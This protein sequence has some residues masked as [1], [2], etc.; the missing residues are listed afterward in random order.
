MPTSSLYGN[1]SDVV[2]ANSSAETT[3]LYTHTVSFGV[4]G[5]TGPT[6]PTGSAGPTGP[7]G[8]QGLVGPT[9][10]T[11]AQGI[12]GIQGPTGPTGSIGATGITGPTGPQGIQGIQGPTGPTGST[13]ATGNTGPTGPT[14][15]ASTVAGPTGPTGSIGSA[16]P[17]GPQGIQGIGGPTGP[18]GSIGPT[19]PAGSGTGDVLGPASSTDNALARFDLTTGKIIQNGVITEDDSG[20]LASVLAQQFSNGSAETVAAGKMWYDGTT[21]SWNLGMGG[22]NITQQVGEELFVYGKAS[23][24]IT[25]SPLQ[26]IY[27]TGT[28]GA[29]GV[30]TFAPTTTGI[31]NGDLIIGVAT[32]SIAL[33]GF[34]RITCF[35]VVHGITT[36]GTAYGE[37]WVDG[38][39]IW[40]NPV[41]GNPTKV[42]PSAPNIKVQVGTIIKAGSGGSGS[43]QVEVSHGS[44]LG[45]T[46]SNVQ[47][48]G[49]ANLNLLQ[50]DSTAQYWK[51]V[52]PSTVTVGNVSGTVAIA[53]GGTGQTTQAAALTA[54]AG[55]Q[56]N[57]YYLRS[58]GTNTSLSALSAAD[59]TGVVS[60]ATGGSGQTT[61]QAAMNAF[62]GAVTSGSYLRGNGTNVVMSS[63]QAADVPTLNQNTTGTA[64]NVTG[65]VAVA[66]GGTGLTTAPANGALDIGNGT[67]FTRTTLTAGSGISVTNA[68]GSITIANTQTPGASLS[69]ANTWTATQTFNGTSSTFGTSLLDS[70]ETVNVV[71]AAPSATTNFYIQSGAVQYYTSNAANNW[72]LNIAFSSG[73][74]LNTALATGQSVTFTLITTQSS[75]AYYANAITIDGTSVTPKWIGGA[76]TAGNASGLDVY[77]FA[78]V[79]TASATYTVLASLTQYK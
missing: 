42:K 23:A 18:T 14:G 75:T 37:T 3:G 78:V 26:I 6:G 32:E 10:P 71:A 31:T 66:N 20:R 7:T 5:P 77:R 57:A 41:T 38:D 50:Y 55:T 64:S 21:G 24:A 61:A 73:T 27:Q 30:I 70:N 48:T 60:I 58:N 46:D 47:L 22:G 17:T 29:S 56:T 19:G 68:S 76:P 72:T 35:G 36:D 54:L 45:G 52:A 33:N 74:S 25:D 4:T 51:N 28:V 16:G 40:Y 11:G 34:G 43:F 39:A 15:A 8:I 53:N 69:T 67:G 65:T 63:I 59:L 9:G 79:K 13:G 2:Q 62:A 12:Q 1:P 44:V 49:V